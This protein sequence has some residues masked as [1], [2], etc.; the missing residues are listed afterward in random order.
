MQ[1]SLQN[2]LEEVCWEDMEMRISRSIS[3]LSMLSGVIEHIDRC[4]KLQRLVALVQYR[5]YL[6]LF[7]LNSNFLLTFYQSAIPLLLSP[8]DYNHTIPSH[9]LL[10]HHFSPFFHQQQ[11]T[12][13]P[14][15]ISPLTQYVP[16]LLRTPRIPLAPNHPSDHHRLPHPFRRPPK[17]GH[18]KRTPG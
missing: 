12:L 15:I 6:H 13:L 1:I 2:T 18:Q 14:S 7:L 16:L 4:R 9:L 8:S 3:N 11:F 17:H 10:H 5:I